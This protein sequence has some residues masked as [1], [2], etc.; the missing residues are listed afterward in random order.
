MKVTDYHDTLYQ[1]NLV[2]DDEK[3][4][5][6]PKMHNISRVKIQRV[7]NEDETRQMSNILLDFLLSFSGCIIFG[8]SSWLGSTEKNR[9]L[10]P[11][12]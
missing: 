11:A 7:I 1:P 9:G 12:L 8:I 2:D 5:L 10:S 3:E 6:I 4:N